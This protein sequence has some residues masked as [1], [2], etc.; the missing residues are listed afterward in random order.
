MH[1]GEKSAH[2]DRKMHEE[3][4]TKA[5]VS[6]CGGGGAR[7]SLRGE[8]V[9]GLFR[10]R[11]N[12]NSSI[13]CW[14]RYG[15]WRPGGGCVSEQVM[16]LSVDQPRVCEFRIVSVFIY[17]LFLS[18]TCRI[19]PQSLQRAPAYIPQH[20]KTSHLILTI[21]RGDRVHFQFRAG[22]EKLPRVRRT[23]RNCQRCW[24]TPTQH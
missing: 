23:A 10:E 24:Q 2:C 22:S 5:D 13:A 4:K 1:A 18:L 21:L 14:R 9:D 11:H 20:I 12:L 15:E 3:V 7:S 16:L 19:C 8:T 17:F 6:K